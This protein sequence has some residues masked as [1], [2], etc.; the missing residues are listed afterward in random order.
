MVGAVAPGVCRR[1][2]ALVGV[3]DKPSEFAERAVHEWSAKVFQD[4]EGPLLSA[5]YGT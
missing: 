2:N 4:E 5:Q 3:L 1:R